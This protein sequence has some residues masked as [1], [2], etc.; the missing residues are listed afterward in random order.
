MMISFIYEGMINVFLFFTMDRESKKPIKDW[1]YF[2]SQIT[3]K[4]YHAWANEA[5]MI[6]HNKDDVDDVLQEA[7]ITGFSYFHQL[8]DEAKFFQWMFKIVR[9]TALDHIEHFSTAKLIA[10]LT[11]ILKAAP[12]S[13]E[14]ALNTVEK[15][16]DL[17]QA[18]SILD[19]QTQNIVMLKTSGINMR[20]IAVQL[21]L[22]YNTV[23]SKYQR[24]LDAM[25]HYMEEQ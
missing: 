8:R 22:N 5:F 25:R 11:D 3:P 17:Q 10:K 7:L 2:L 4:M 12:L 9:R 23:R 21:N 19:D 24:G 18:L 6:L 14:A 16:N 1:D 15:N 13:P 20:K